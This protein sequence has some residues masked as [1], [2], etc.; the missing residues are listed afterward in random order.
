MNLLNFIYLYQLNDDKQLFEII[1]LHTKDKEKALRQCI[2]FFATYEEINGKYYFY[3]NTSCY[4][5]YGGNQYQ[6]AK[7][8]KNIYF[9]LLKN[10]NNFFEG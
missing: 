4:C 10:K 7:S 9:L 1:N 2:K 5:W 3:T 8:N 6:L